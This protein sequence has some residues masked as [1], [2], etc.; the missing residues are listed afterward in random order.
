MCY[1]RP[2]APQHHTDGTRSSE[3]ILFLPDL[4]LWAMPLSRA[5]LYVNP[6]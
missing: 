3:Q 1:S 5:N 6:M 4:S 2:M